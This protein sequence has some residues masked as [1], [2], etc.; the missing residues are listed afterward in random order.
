[1][2][3]WLRVNGDAIYGTTAGPFAHLS[4]GVATRLRQD[5]GGQAR[6]TDR[7]FLHVFDWPKDGQL[8]VPL[9]S[10]AKSAWLLSAPGKKLALTREADRL[11]VTVPATAPDAVN[12]V[13]VLELAGEPVVPPLPTVGA[14]ATASAALAGSEAAHAL[15]GTAAKRWRAPADVKSASLEIDLG[16]PIAISGFGLDEPDVWPRMRQSYLLEVADGGAWKK[17]AEG[18]TDGHG[19]KRAIPTVTAQKFRLTME[20]AAGS[21]GVAELQL[22]RPE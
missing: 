3:R 20:C 15:D 11:I 8:R 17:I 12:S 7:L 4:W 9:Q 1:M 2:G 6:K 22:Y 13:V 10:A 19:L 5:F 18:R 14:K 16:R 21:P